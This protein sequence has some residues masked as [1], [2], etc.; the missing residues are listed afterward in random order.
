MDFVCLVIYLPHE[1]D[2]NGLL[3]IVFLVQAD[4]IDPQIP[5]LV[6]LSQISQHLVYIWS[7][8]H[9]RS[10]VVA[11][12]RHGEYRGFSP[13]I[14]DRLVI[15][16]PGFVSKIRPVDVNDVGVQRRSEFG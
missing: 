5:R 12:E 14:T 10:F 2:L 13:A 7:D 8:W 1:L 16:N 9:S 11:D 15:T 6:S 4:G 3:V